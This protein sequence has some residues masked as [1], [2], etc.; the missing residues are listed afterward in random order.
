[1][2]NNTSS[3]IPVV[4]Y[5]SVGR[6]IPD[7]EWSFL[8]VPYKIFENHLKWLVKA[9]YKTVDLYELNAH[10]SGKKILLNRCVVLTFDDGYLDNWGYVAPLLSKYGLKGTVFVNPEFVDPR[11]IIRPT[12]KDVW[13]GMI[14]EGDVP[15]HGFMSWPELKILSESGPLSIQSHGM[16]H[17]WYPSGSKIIDFHHP[18]DNMYWLDW[19]KYPKK[20]PFYLSNLNKSNVA[21][22]TPIYKHGKALSI[23][24]FFPNHSLT[25]ELIS[26]VSKN[27]G[28]LFF[29]NK[30]W[31]RK[32]FSEANTPKNKQLNTGYF[33]TEYDRDFRYRYELS[34]S[35]RILEE[36]LGKTV[37]FFFWPG[38]GYNERSQSIAL[39][40]YRAITLKS[41]DT[42]DNKNRIGDDHRLIRRIAPHGFF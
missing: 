13:S 4:M 36:K 41:S 35:K 27:G 22:G 7:W 38:G 9:G 28:L 33:E 12:I 10:V 3:G 1:M 5:H 21:F 14:R 25:K 18:G 23:T 11:N 31:R 20:K 34:E 17:T 19:N 6:T 24:K 16:S 2:K 40:L 32:L 39:E 37:D 15:I 30:E 8:T 26:Y 42:S 29:D